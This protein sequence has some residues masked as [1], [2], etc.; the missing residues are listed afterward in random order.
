MK[1]VL[2]QKMFKKIRIL[3]LGKRIQIMSLNFR[4]Q[5][6]LLQAKASSASL[7]VAQD[8]QLRKFEK[9]I[10]FKFNR[11]T[12]DRFSPSRARCAENCVSALTH[13]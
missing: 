11:H 13:R 4:Q 9:T 1:I 8:R 10:F 6:R 7:K 12:P 3:G 5:K 2:N